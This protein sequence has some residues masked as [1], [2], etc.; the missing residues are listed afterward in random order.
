MTDTTESLRK[1][2]AALLRKEQKAEYLRPY[3]VELS[4]MVVAALDHADR[5]E[6]MEVHDFL[7]S[8]RMIAHIWSV[9]DVQEVRPD[10][11]GDQAWEVL[12][13]VDRRMDSEYGVTWQTL[14]DAADDLFP[15][16]EAA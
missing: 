15:P 8:R 9:E 11:T 16:K 14:E 12:Q 4:R 2:H 7:A 10:L 5:L 1:Q 3:F 6:R 13:A